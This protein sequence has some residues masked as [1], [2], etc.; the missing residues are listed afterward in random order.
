M[1]QLLNLN[2]EQNVFYNSGPSLPDDGQFQ[3]WQKTWEKLHLNFY[4]LMLL[5]IFVTEMLF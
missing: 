1:T 5:L 3:I 2:L 4:N